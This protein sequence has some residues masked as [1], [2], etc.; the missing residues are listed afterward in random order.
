MA[1]IDV[2]HLT[3]KT[4][5]DSGTGVVDVLMESIKLHLKEQY[6]EDRI[7]GPEFAQVFLGSLQSIIQQSIAFVLQEQEAGK[8]VD[9]IDQQI[10]SEQENVDLIRAKTAQAYAEVAYL[11]GKNTREN[12]LNNK[13]LLKLQAEIDLLVAQR[14][15]V[16]TATEAEGFMAQAKLEKE[17]GFAVT[18]DAVNNWQ[19]DNIASGTGGNIDRKNDLMEAQTLGFSTDTKQKVLKQMFE[20]YAVNLSIAGVGNIPEAAQDAAIDALAQNILDDVGATNI[21]NLTGDTDPPAL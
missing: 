6:E 3:S 8:K 14:T 20:N 15:Q 1:D 19:I 7:I 18:Q 4:E 16:E 2:T 10:L 13:Q 9:L 12:L 21:I 11:E 5:Q 17:L